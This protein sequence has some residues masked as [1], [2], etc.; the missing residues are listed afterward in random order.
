MIPMRALM[1]RCPR[2]GQAMVEYSMLNWV[3]LVGLM[4]ASTVKIIPGPQER[5][6]GNKV[7]ILDA[8]LFAAQSYLESV[9]YVLNQPF[10]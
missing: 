9:A 2:R 1:S 4:M 8:F 6:A 3:L 10:P 5:F 7:N